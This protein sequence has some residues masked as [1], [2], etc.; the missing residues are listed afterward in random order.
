VSAKAKPGGGGIADSVN[1]GKTFSALATIKDE[2]LRNDCVRVRVPK[3]LRDNWTI[4]T[5]ND[6]RNFLMP[7]P[8]TLEL[9]IS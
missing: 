4:H 3:R 7:D 6:R 9:P 8:I 1:F 5:T 2:E